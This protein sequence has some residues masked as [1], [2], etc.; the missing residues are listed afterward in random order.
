MMVSPDGGGVCALLP[1]LRRRFWR[2]FF[3]VNGAVPT[4][5]VLFAAAGMTASAG[6]F[7]CFFLNFFGYVHPSCFDFL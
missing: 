3:G 4:G 6:F 7:F 2:S 5:V 1:S